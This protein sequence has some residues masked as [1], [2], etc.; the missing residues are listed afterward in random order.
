MC[1]S[2][3]SNALTRGLY[4]SLLREQKLLHRQTRQSQNLSVQ[5][6]SFPDDLDGWHHFPFNKVA[7]DYLVSSYLLLVTDQE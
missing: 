5:L 2:T 7:A 1:S 3:G 6:L 4:M